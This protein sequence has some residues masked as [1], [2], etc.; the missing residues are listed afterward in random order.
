MTET[1]VRDQQ[2]AINQVFVDLVAYGRIH[3]R[4]ELFRWRRPAETRRLRHS[5]DVTYPWCDGYGIWIEDGTAI[6]VALHWMAEITEVTD[7][8][9][10]EVLCAQYATPTPVNLALV[11]CASWADELV[12]H[13]HLVTHPATPVVATTTA[14]MMGDQAG[15]AATAVWAKTADAVRGTRE[16]LIPMPADR[17][18]TQ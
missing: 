7:E 4:A 13:G 15:G 18:A 10:C 1:S 3:G 8:L 2:Y 6:T 11:V 17:T 9:A 5:R 14:S 12:M 16:R